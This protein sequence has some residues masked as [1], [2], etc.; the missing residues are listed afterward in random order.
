MSAMVQLGNG[1]HNA[2]H[3]EDALSVEEAHLSMLRRLGAPEDDILTAQGNLAGTYQM[4]G[5]F[6][7]A[8]SME[9]DV[10]SGWLR[11][12][13]EDN[14][15][16]ITAANNY[17]VSLRR[18]DRFKEA[19]ALLHKS[20]P[21]ARRVLGESHSLTLTMRRIYAIALYEDASATLDDLREAVTTLEEVERIARRVM[22]GAHPTTTGIKFYLQEARAVLRARETPPA[23]DTAEE[24]N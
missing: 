15:A 5:R 11:D 24:R 21:I 4:L 23:G 19:K 14:E 8:L 7:E 16:T 1:L 17:A 22:G 20:I 9:R 3:H 2:G 6:E 18:L 13:G 12:S 10:Y